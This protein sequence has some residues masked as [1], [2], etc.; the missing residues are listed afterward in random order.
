MVLL[1][2]D[3]VLREAPAHPTAHLARGQARL[4]TGDAGGARDDLEQQTRLA[5]DSAHA[6]LLLAEARRA[7]GD[8][9]GA[10]QAQARG[11]APTAGAR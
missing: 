5:P 1:K 9:E 7:L 10:R 4:K 6:W 11:R 2:L 8:E 3:V